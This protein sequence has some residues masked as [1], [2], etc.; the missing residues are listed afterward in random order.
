MAASFRKRWGLTWDIHGDGKTINAGQVVKPHERMAWP[1][2]IGIGLQHVMAMFGSTVLVP[3]LTG[4]PPTAALF[5]SGV[6][7]LLFLVITKGKV[8]SYL[9][10]S[11]AFIAPMVAATSMH[12]MAVASGGIIITGLALAIVGFLVH[13]AGTR[14]IHAVMPPVVMGTI[15][16]LI[17]LNLAG[18]TTEGMIE[19][20]LTT[21][22]TTAAVIITAVLFRGFLGRLSIL[23]GIVV[24]YL[25]A[26]AQQQIDFQ[27]VTEASW[28]GLP[29]FHAPEFQFDVLFLFLPVVFVLVAENIGHV[30][31]VGLMTRNNLDP[32]NGRALIADGLATMLSGS[33]GG[34]GT[35]T[36]AE[37]IGVMA[38]SRIYST[39]AYWVAGIVAMSL[40][41]FPKFGA[42]IATIPMGVAAGAG[43]ILYGMIG[44]MGAR[45]WVNNEV[46][47][48]NTINLMAA[49]SGLI[50]AIADPVVEV[51]GMQFG[52]IALGT[53]AALGIYHLMTAIARWRNTEPIEEDDF[54]AVE[55]GRIG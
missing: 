37:N 41:F 38:S 19:V 26:L 17:G 48:S 55:P 35:T 11:F 30:R 49:G 14:W 12:S 10:S 13:K 20:P 39:A 53:L 4:F 54:E 42:L 52:G 43:I 32:H 25:L 7:T 8:P 21:F 5:F 31:T 9:G 34:V 40:A 18:A 29:A 51:A 23:L 16:A 45:I 1:Q 36:Y 27:P 24:G 46:D 2:T 50:I 3:A 6:G 22:G 15:L 47:F 44:I 33:G 28:I